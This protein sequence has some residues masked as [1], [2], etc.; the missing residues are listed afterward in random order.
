MTKPFSPKAA[1]GHVAKE[2]SSMGMEVKKDEDGSTVLIGRPLDLDFAYHGVPLMVRYVRR[3]VDEIE[4]T[5]NVEPELSDW[6]AGL[7]KSL[8]LHLQDRFSLEKS[9]G[10]RDYVDITKEMAVAITVEVTRFARRFTRKGVRVAGYVNGENYEDG[11][12]YVSCWI[13]LHWSMSSKYN[14]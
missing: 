1:L 6:I 8:H 12:T 13:D 2:L 9:M 14:K 10:L 7:N 4:Y 11:R 3:P 5:V